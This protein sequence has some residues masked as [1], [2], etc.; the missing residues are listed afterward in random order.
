M[1]ATPKALGGSTRE[2]GNGL[3]DGEDPG[4]K[5][6]DEEIVTYSLTQVA[7]WD[8]AFSIYGDCLF[9]AKCNTWVKTWLAVRNER[10]NELA[11]T[12][13]VENSR[14][15]FIMESAAREVL[16]KGRVMF[17]HGN[18]M[19]PR[20]TKFM[21][22]GISGNI[23]LK[24]K[25]YAILPNGAKGLFFGGKFVIPSVRNTILVDVETGAEVC[26]I[27]KISDA[28]LELD[29]R[30]GLSPIHVFTIAMGAWLGP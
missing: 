4:R 14:Q 19:T 16:A 17:P 12:L 1:S 8:F 29:A 13:K 2:N 18:T 21:G 5:W 11:G 26:G 7:S 3:S 30:A 6:D 22:H 27:R 28:V 23:K 20:K 24:S 25:K 9:R 15:L 10:T